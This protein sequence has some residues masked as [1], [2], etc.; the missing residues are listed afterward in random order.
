MKLKIFQFQLPV[1]ANSREET[2]TIEI[3]ADTAQD[4]LSTLHAM[5]TVGRELTL[6]EAGSVTVYRT[7]STYTRP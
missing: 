3:C 2:A 1:I 6:V 5:L 4:L 7:P